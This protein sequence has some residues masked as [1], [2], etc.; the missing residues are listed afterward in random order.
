MNFSLCN[1]FE[2]TFKCKSFDMK[3]NEQNSFKIEDGKNYF[4]YNPFII[5]TSSYI[6]KKV[7]KNLYQNI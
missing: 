5:S 1:K 7:I 4:D 2:F 3:F 6:I